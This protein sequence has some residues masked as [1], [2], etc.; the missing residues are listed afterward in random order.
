LDR[1]GITTPDN[2]GNLVLNDL[3]VGRYSA[4]MM[5]PGWPRL[6]E[7]SVN[8]E[9]GKT[10]EA[11]WVFEPKASASLTLTVQDKNAAPWSNREILIRSQVLNPADGQAT[12]DFI[13]G[14]QPFFPGSNLRR[15]TTDAQGK[16]TLYPLRPGKYRLWVAPRDASGNAGRGNA[17]DQEVNVPAEGGAATFKLQVPLPAP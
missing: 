9:A 7:Q 2:D 13:P 1:S 12:M 6:P 8:I 3:P 16:L 14:M 10:A 17:V 15:G 4:I 11:E 5:L